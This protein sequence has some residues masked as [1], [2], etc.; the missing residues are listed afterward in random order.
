V[1]SVEKVTMQAY[2]VCHQLKLSIPND[3]KVIGFSHLQIASLLNPSLTTITQP[4]FEMG[5]TAATILFK[6]LS[7]K[8][9]EWKNEKVVIP[10]V[11]VERESTRQIMTSIAEAAAK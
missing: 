3:V 5:K 11:L 9:F 10:S 2:T 1:G 8:M 7:K 4:A 6:A